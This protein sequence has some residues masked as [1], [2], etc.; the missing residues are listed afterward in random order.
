MRGG[1]VQME[2]KTGIILLQAKDTRS[3]IAVRER[4]EPNPPWSQVSHIHNC[5]KTQLC[6]RNYL[7]TAFG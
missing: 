1:Y 4:Q 6:S 7:S 5:K 3:N 2:A